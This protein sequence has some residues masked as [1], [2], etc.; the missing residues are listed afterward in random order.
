MKH[1][2]SVASVLA[3]M[4]ASASALPFSPTQPSSHVLERRSG[5]YLKSCTDS[6]MSQDA[7]GHWQIIARCRNNVGGYQ[8]SG[9][10]LNLCLANLDGKLTWQWNGNF[11]SS[12]YNISPADPSSIAAECHPKA[13]TGVWNVVDLNQGIHNYNGFIRCW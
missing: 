1:T 9:L 4:L 6:G 10:D 2:T 12:C 3:A 5:D 8:V 13:G 7:N 11:Q